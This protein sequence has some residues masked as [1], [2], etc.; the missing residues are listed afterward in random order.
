MGKAAGLHPVKR[1]FKSLRLHHLAEFSATSCLK[2]LGDA[3]NDGGRE[4]IPAFARIA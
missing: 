2:R 3:I 1:E 4:L